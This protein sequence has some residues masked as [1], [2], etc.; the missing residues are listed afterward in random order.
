MTKLCFGV[1]LFLAL[2]TTTQAQE[3]PPSNKPKN[4]EI[5]D[6]GTVTVRGKVSFT[7]R[8]RDVHEKVQ[9]TVRALL[10]YANDGAQ[11]VT[12]T[13]IEIIDGAW[14]ATFHRPEHAGKQPASLSF[15]EA[16]VDDTQVILETESLAVT[17]EP[18][19][20]LR[21]RAIPELRLSVFDA[22]TKKAIGRVEVFHARGNWDDDNTLHP[23]VNAKMQRVVDAGESPFLVPPPDEV[24]PNGTTPVWIRAPGYA[25]HTLQV[26]FA[27]GGLRE[28]PLVHGG[29]AKISI[30]NKVPAAEKLAVRVYGTVGTQSR[31]L[32]DLG[33]PRAVPNL[34]EDLAPGRYEVRLELGDWF[35]EPRVLGKAPMEIQA[36]Q[37]ASVELVVANE[38]AAPERVMFSGIVVVPA[39]WQRAGQ[40]SVVLDPLRG[41]DRWTEQRYLHGEQLKRGE[42][43]GEYRFTFPE[44]VV[45][46]YAL[47]FEPSQYQK[48]V[49]VTK[50]GATDLRIELPEPV[51]IVIRVVDRETKR[52]R[53]GVNL[54]WHPA[55]P[56]DAFGG[57]SEGASAAPDSNEVRILVPAGHIEVSAHDDEFEVRTTLNVSPDAREFEVFAD[58]RHAVKVAV[59]EGTTRIPIGFRTGWDV[60]LLTVDGKPALASESW[61]SSEVTM[62]VLK[63]GTY[64]LRVTPPDG[65]LPVADRQVKLAPPPFPTIDVKVARK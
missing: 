10:W 29:S 36:G 27:E 57:S 7:D 55:W 64:L 53:N 43:E 56:L 6:D 45:G 34:L 22:E 35:R 14:V 16:R 61:S 5:G 1:L 48:V 62:S 25:W 49:R 15:S 4:L 2:G 37:E 40:L 23:G 18:D 41:T 30:A 58:V 24:S 8:K 54:S 28:V 47:I 17:D 51:E 26:M 59:Y 21:L 39:G 44:T 50:E 3:P 52:P 63:P 31:P 38:V 12:A 33:L 13:P 60:S 42:K 19:F 65:Y 46:R 11:A 32:L 9:G 20:V